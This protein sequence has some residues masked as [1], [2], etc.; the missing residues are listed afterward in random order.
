MPKIEVDLHE[1]VRQ[2]L[3]RYDYDG[4]FNEGVCGCEL[5]DLM[6]CSEPQMDCQPGYKVP[7]DPATC[8]EG[9]GCNYHIAAV[10]NRTGKNE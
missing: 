1:I 2:W 7:C 3:S 6:P 8:E 10:K 5:S 4:L 9:G